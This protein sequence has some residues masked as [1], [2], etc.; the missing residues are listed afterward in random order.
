M[1]SVP[2]NLYTEPGVEGVLP[3]T[4]QYYIILIQGTY[5]VYTRSLGHSPHLFFVDSESSD[6]DDHGYIYILHDRCKGQ[7]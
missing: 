6:V 5:F 4:I 3:K 7:G 2:K 1:L